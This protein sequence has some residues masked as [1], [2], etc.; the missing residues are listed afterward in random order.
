MRGGKRE[1][2]GRPKGSVNKL[3]ASSTLPSGHDCT[4]LTNLLAV[5]RDASVD[6][7]RRDRAAELLLTF[8]HERRPTPL[9]LPPRERARRAEH[10][11]AQ[12]HEAELERAL[13]E[14]ARRYG[15]H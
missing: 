8:L 6:V 3:E 11:E 9:A 5:L 1:G 13:D 4:P 2:A 14:V 12:T 15:E 7:R 10:Q